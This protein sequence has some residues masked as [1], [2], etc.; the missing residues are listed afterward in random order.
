MCVMSEIEREQVI[1][2]IVAA[3][4]ETSEKDPAVCEDSA[5]E[6]PAPVPSESA[7]K[8]WLST[9]Y[10]LMGNVA[11]ALIIVTALFS[12]CFR[13]VVVDGAS[14]N[15]TLAHGDRLLLQTVFYEVERQDIVVIYQEDEPEKPLIKRVIALGG[16][17]LR[18]NPRANGGMGE[19]Y[20]KKAGENDWEL[21]NEPY[22]QYPMGWGIG[23]DLLAETEITVPQ[24][25]VFV[26]GDH[27][28]DSKDS[29]S[30]SVGCVKAENVV[31]GVL[32]SLIPFK[33][34]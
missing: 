8:S 29:R 32:F 16:D 4:E 13:Q 33:G 31:G 15:D 28:N 23:G 17:S 20:L 11:L 30:P 9:L 18:L 26:M 7:S 27:R 10:E 14:M 21:L 12:F 19:V 3:E 25:H 1:E 6:K 34:V 22:V 5:E 2:E 24:G